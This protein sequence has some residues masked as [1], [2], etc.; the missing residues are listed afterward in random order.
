MIRSLLE[1]SIPAAVQFTS[2]FILLKYEGRVAWSWALVLAP[3]WGPVI[4]SAILICRKAF[5]GR[6][7]IFCGREDAAVPRRQDDLQ[8]RSR[9]SGIMPCLRE[10][11]LIGRPWR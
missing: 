11:K 6:A 9:R 2:L 8:D 1:I 3:A 10:T 4:L 5:G 7:C